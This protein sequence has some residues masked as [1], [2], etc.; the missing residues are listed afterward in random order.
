MR[1]TTGQ[2]KVLCEAEKEKIIKDFL[3]FIKY[4]A[5]RLSWR[6]PPQLTIDDLISVGTMGLLDA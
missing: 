5:H 6:L 1:G 4:T 3:P 2:E